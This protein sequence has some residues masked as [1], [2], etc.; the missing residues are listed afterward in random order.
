MRSIDFGRWGQGSLIL[1]L[2][3]EVLEASCG[4]KLLSAIRSIDEAIESSV[5]DSHPSIAY[6]ITQEAMGL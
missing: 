5:I 1:D 4:S 3:G 6:K 2:Y